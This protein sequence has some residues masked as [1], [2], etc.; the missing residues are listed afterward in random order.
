MPI[1]SLKT[2]KNQRFPD[3]SRRY[4]MDTV[5]WSGS[6]HIRNFYENGAVGIL[7]KHKHFVLYFVVELLSVYQIYQIY[8]FYF[9]KHYIYLLRTHASS[10]NILLLRYL[11]CSKNNFIQ[12]NHCN[13]R[14]PIFYICCLFSD[15]SNCFGNKFCWRF[16]LLV[17]YFHM[18]PKIFFRYACLFLLYFVNFI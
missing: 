13:S 18:F 11:E 4:R 9:Q 10:P 2:S 15:K 5:A 3:D 14:K 17:Y 1:Y 8:S 6:M 12:I 7:K 16:L